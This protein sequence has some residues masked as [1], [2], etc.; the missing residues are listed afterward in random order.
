MAKSKT[1]IAEVKPKIVKVVK[2]VSP[3]IE[4]SVANNVIVSTSVSNVLESNNVLE[5]TP[6]QYSTLFFSPDIKILLID[7]TALG[8]SEG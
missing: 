6:S 5:S 3:I 7:V 1:T 4:T 8:V 2:E